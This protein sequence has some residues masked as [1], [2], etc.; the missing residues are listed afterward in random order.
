MAVHINREYLI[1]RRNAEDFDNYEETNLFFPELR[2]KGYTFIENVGVS[3]ICKRAELYKNRGFEV[4]VEDYGYDMDGK[5][6]EDYSIFL[7]NTDGSR[8]DLTDSRLS[9]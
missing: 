1:E 4:F 6:I 5:T 3:Q 7:R 2:E 8:I 9:Q